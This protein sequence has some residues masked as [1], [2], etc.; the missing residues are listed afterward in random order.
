[1]QGPDG[2]DLHFDI[3]LALQDDGAT[4]VIMRNVTARKQAEAEQARLREQL[5]LAQSRQVVS[6]I[7]A[8]LA[9]D[10]SNV[11]S[12]LSGAVDILAPHCPP[13]AE[14][15]LARIREATRRANGLA[16]NL[17]R[18]GRERPAAQRTD[19]AAVLQQ[20]VAMLRPGLTRQVALSIALPNDP[21]PVHGNEIELMQVALNL[22]LNARDAC[23]ESARDDP[24]QEAR[25]Q[26]IVVGLTPT[27]RFA[28]PS[29]FEV[30]NL[31]PDLD[32]AMIEIADTGPGIAPSLRRRVFE[33][34]FTTKGADGA[35]LGLAVVADIVLARGGALTLADAPDG[36]TRVQL[37]WPHT[38]P[39]AMAVADGAPPLAG[40]H[41]L[42]VDDDDNVLQELSGLLASAGAEVVSCTDPA[43]AI[44]AVTEDPMAW[45]LVVTDFDMENMSGT[46]LTRALHAQRDGLPVVLMSGDRQLHFASACDLYQWYCRDLAQTRVPIRPDT[47][48]FWLRSCAR[49]MLFDGP[50]GPWPCAFS[51]PTITICC[52]TRCAAFCSG[53][54]ISTSSPSPI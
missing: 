8:G 36:G 2:A 40:T 34:H 49:G 28:Q 35:G 17:T 41:V 10:F 3:S 54:T 32:Y 12:A 4:L 19:L 25:T 26:R 27:Q 15:Q 51:S 22:L 46:A 23:V 37:F 39:G 44:E 20:T 45:D 50:E 9:H 43:D 47:G 24:G 38:A 16:Q 53:M 6:Q 52:A 1:M 18:L 11:L 30:G 13:A 7:A 29:G 33:P 48:F 21:V 5:Q 31:V 14:T 42:L